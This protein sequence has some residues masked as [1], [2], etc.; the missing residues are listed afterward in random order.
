MSKDFKTWVYH[1]E[2]KAKIVMSSEVEKL[3]KHGWCDSPAKCVAKPKK[4]KKAK[5]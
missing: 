2:H 1:I 3:A 5:K 4:A